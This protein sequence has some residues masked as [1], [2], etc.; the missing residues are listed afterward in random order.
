MGAEIFGQRVE[1]HGRVLAQFA[2]GSRPLQARLKRQQEPADLR[3]S[4]GQAVVGLGA[5]RSEARL[6]GVQPVHLNIALRLATNRERLGVRDRTGVIDQEVAVEG[7]HAIRL[8]EVGVHARFA[9]QGQP[10]A[11]Q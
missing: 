1:E 3:S 7:Q 4:Q 5:G 11:G 2:G 10:T 9:T 8:G 6:D